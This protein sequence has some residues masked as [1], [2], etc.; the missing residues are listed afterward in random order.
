MMDSISS[1]N[2]VPSL[3][4]MG[5]FCLYSLSFQ[6]HLYKYGTMTKAASAAFVA[7]ASAMPCCGGLGM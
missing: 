6:F 3:Y 4:E 2:M 5:M 7:R 1:Q